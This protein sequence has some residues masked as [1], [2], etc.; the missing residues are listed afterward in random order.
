MDVGFKANTRPRAGERVWLSGVWAEKWLRAGAVA[1]EE[2]GEL[3]VSEPA[4]GYH[5]EVFV[6]R[7]ASLATLTCNTVWRPGRCNTDQISS[8]FSQT[9]IIN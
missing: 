5:H 1:H 9:L 6:H 2:P 3:V 4:P 7:P 8:Y